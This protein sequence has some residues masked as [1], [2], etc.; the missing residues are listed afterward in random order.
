MLA[1]R[2]SAI[3]AA[4]ALLLAPLGAA[5]AAFIL[6]TNI[7]YTVASTNL[8]DD[9]G[10]CDGQPHALTNNTGGAVG[11]GNN[12]ATGGRFFIG[13]NAPPA[14]NGAL[15]L[16][17]TSATPGTFY[18]NG[19]NPA[20]PIVGRLGHVS[21]GNWTG[22]LTI[23]GGVRVVMGNRRLNYEGGTNTVTVLNGLLDY[24]TN[25]A[26]GFN[27][28]N[29]G[30]SP[31]VRHILGTNGTLSLDGLIT[32]AAG[33]SAWAVSGGTSVG[34]TDITV[35]PVNGA[36]LLFTQNAGA[37]TTTIGAVPL[38]PT[39]P[40]IVTAPQSATYLLGGYMVPLTVTASG[41]LPFSYQWR[42]D[43]VVLSGATNATFS[44]ST[45]LAVAD[46]GNYTVII[47]NS[48]GSVTSTPPSTITV[49]NLTTPGDQAA[50]IVGRYQSV[51]SSP[52]TQVPS[53]GPVNTPLMGNGSMLATLGGQPNKLQFY[54]NRS[55]QW[56]MIANGGGGPR[57]LAR[58][59]VSLPGLQGGS[60]SVQQDFLH[61][62]T[63]GQFVS[64]GVALNMES[65]VAATDD[66]LW[67]LLS[68]TSGSV[69]G[70]ADLFLPGAGGLTDNANHLQL[71][72]EQ[73]G[74][75]RWYLDGL[76]DEVRVYSRALSATEV[77]TLSSTQ[78]VSGN[79]I[80]WWTFDNLTNSTVPDMS[81]S[82]ANGT[83]VGGVSVTN[84]VSGSALNLNGATGYVDTSACQVQS[85]LT[86]SAFINVRSIA[87]S[88]NA[89]YILSKGEWS[90]GWSLGL[91][92]GYLRMAVGSSYA[93]TTTLIPT[94]QWVHVAGTYD[95][96][97]I[98]AYINGQLVATYGGGGGGDYGAVQ[99]VERDFLTGVSVPDAAAAALQVVGSP[100][101]TF[102]V[103]TNQPVLLVVSSQGLLVTTNFFNDA[104]NRAGA[105]Q[106]ADFT[107]LRSAHQ[108]WWS[109]F[110]GKSFVE[111]PDQ[112]LMQRYYLSH[113]V[114]AS[115][116]RN[117]NFPPGLQGWVT[118]DSPMWSGD[119]HLNYNF[120]A[121]F[122]GLYAA[123]HVEQA[124]PYNQPI[125]DI[126]GVGR[127]LGV[128]Q[129]GINGIYLP[130]GIAPKGNLVY[131]IYMGQKSNAGYAC[132]PLAQ[133][134][135]TTRDLAFAAAAYPFFRDVA[136]FWENYLVYTNN[137]NGVAGARYVDFSDSVHESSGN[138]INPL[139]SLSFIRLV[140]NCA[141]D[142]STSLGVDA[143]RH[144]NWQNILTNLSAYPTYRVADLG[145]W[146]SQLP[147]TATVSNLPV[148]RYTEVGTAWWS[149][150][151]VGIQH[152]YPGNGIG[153]DSPP[154]LLQRATNQIYVMSRWLD[155]N[156]MSSFF[157]AAARVG[158]DPNTIL[159]QL[160]NMVASWGWAN[161]FYSANGGWMENESVVPNTIQEMLM[162]SQEGVIRFFP[163][164]PTNLDGR[165]GTLRAYG[166]FLVSAQ[167]HN[168]LVAG[169]HI[170]SEKGQPCTVQ[171]PW[172]GQSVAVTRNG[173]L[174]EVVSGARFTLPT[175]ANETL[176]L[177]PA[178]AYDMW[179][180]Q[181]SNPLLRNPSA[182]ANG[183]GLPNLVEYLLAGMNPN[184]R[185]P[186]PLP[187]VVQ[188]GGQSYLQM[189]LLKNP[190]ATSG[191]LGLQM[192]YDLAHWFA[193]V[194]SGDG[195]L[196]VLNDA[197][198]LT[199]QLRQ[200]MA[201]HAYFRIV[202][203]P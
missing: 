145:W 126:A 200:G 172:P 168:G 11:F 115:A 156:G 171:N 109:N 90:S 146:P 19:Y 69:T 66:L 85:G 37:G 6:N 106:M 188:L 201:A 138:D 25:P 132:V 88:G 105:F 170:T 52:P 158:Y 47:A 107:P 179:A 167:Q 29:A 104:T 121:P 98:R 194:S 131:T 84:G 2:L 86:V 97:A 80:R 143:A 182:D 50:A 58:L 7:L 30:N 151:T 133:R 111:I 67:V 154:D 93:Q 144:A 108:T 150:N 18:L 139:V 190:Q 16:T 202:A 54:L 130:V 70:R 76:L 59:D 23:D 125:F 32:N 39:A 140:L 82:G 160:D 95:G 9:F 42:K 99:A 33:F 92:Q 119:L 43:G 193:P 55:D 175:S 186:M 102:T 57:P 56:V 40:T 203:Q 118:T 110:W 71:G 77:A 152:I 185:N 127:Q 49:Q 183:D 46:A 116:S 36:M 26:F 53:D 100:D 48:V 166:A 60:Y 79:L 196:I 5:R 165:F 176:D 35:E 94:N 153:L 21:G 184:V 68:T 3:T 78:S 65:A 20:D 22:T 195:D 113:Y 169:V 74:S 129:L 41:S 31:H 51:F 187:T 198:Q 128:S 142:M 75:G 101:R 163:C 17:S 28:S 155:N 89:Q 159:A 87:S 81:G 192:S 73:Y 124:E 103:T 8:T 10:W 96:S 64:N 38:P 161:G 157:P 137:Y 178:S 72:R 61:G 177:A 122:Y 141:L 180:Q 189:Q 173:L 4:S 14:G 164:W 181:I 112:T 149:D 1:L 134:W 174:G 117:P 83:Q 63:T 147:H 27:R 24:A 34:A 45:P 162:Q 13:A 123:N 62:L 135:Y 91:S 114:M 148:F 120:E 15:T 136:Q 12:S 44:L 197:T 199:V 191:T